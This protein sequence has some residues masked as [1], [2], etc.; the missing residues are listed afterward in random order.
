MISIILVSAGVVVCILLSA[1]FS[2]SEMAFSACNT[3]RLEN[4][5]EEKSKGWRNARTA[6]KVARHFDDSLSAI[7]IGN[8]LVNI[9]ASSLASVLLILVM[10]SDKYTWLSTLVLTVLVIIFGETI[11]KIY[12]K[13]N[14]TAVAMRFAK[15]VSV[16]I[17]IFRPVI[18]IIVG[19]VKLI[20]LGIKTEKED[21]EE[22]VEELQSII[23][24]AEDEGIIDEDDSMLMQAAIDFADISASEVMTARVDVHAIDIDDSWAEIRTSIEESPYSRIPVY[25]DS[26]DNIIGILHLNTVLKALTDCDETAPKDDPESHPIDLRALLMPPCFVYKTMKLPQVLNVLK[27]AKQHLA[28]VTDEYSGTLGIISME[29]VLEQIVGEIYDETDEVDPDVVK[30]NDNEFE[31]DGDLSI[32][33]FVELAGLDEDSFEAESETAGGWVVE[34]LG[35]F[36]TAGEELESDG[37]IVKVLSMDGLR[38]E[39]LL[40]RIAGQETEKDKE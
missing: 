27:N 2:G 22:S 11:P 3:V 19:L 28:V 38:V 20:T 18:W 30:K 13:K 32:G 40:V 9:A 36:P 35:H 17:F 21:S 37:L 34:K 29:D 23:E 4:I 1:F 10:G 8:N 33:E 31:V 14:A 12:C 7:L 26:I 24:T 15:P 5:S 25:Q 16:L 6:L 39:K